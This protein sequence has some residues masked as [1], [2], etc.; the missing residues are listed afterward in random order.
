MNF[1]FS[2][3]GERSLEK[4]DAMAAKRILK[5]LEY[6]ETTGSPLKYAKKLEGTETLFK[7]RVGSYRIIVK[8]KREENLLVV[9]EIDSRDHVYDDLQKFL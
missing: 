1:W 9:L 6:W 3:H 4:L 8:A 2:N 5:K 7:F